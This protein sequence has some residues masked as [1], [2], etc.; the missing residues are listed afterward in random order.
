MLSFYRILGM[1]DAHTQPCPT[2]PA[3]VKEDQMQR[4]HMY[5]DGTYTESAS[6]KYFDSYNPF[7]GDV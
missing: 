7:T 4:Y 5:I 1:H 3:T 2:E 6:G